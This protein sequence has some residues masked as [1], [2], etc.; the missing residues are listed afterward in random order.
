MCFTRISSFGTFLS[1][2]LTAAILF[3]LAS[4]QIQGTWKALDSYYAVHK[5]AL[6]PLANVS[7]TSGCCTMQYVAAESR[8]CT[9]PSR[10]SG[11]S[12]VDLEIVVYD[13]A[14]CGSAAQEQ[15]VTMTFAT[16][17]FVQQARYVFLNRD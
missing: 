8:N 3:N 12:R 6:S 9:I 13:G 7:A 1:W 17:S 15:T 2:L 10:M 16:P 11:I 14:I 5:S 4:A